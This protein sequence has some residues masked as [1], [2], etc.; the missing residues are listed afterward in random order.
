MEIIDYAEFNP[1]TKNQYE[2]FAI[3]CRVCKD[4]DSEI[5]KELNDFKTQLPKL[6]SSILIDQKFDVAESDKI[7]NQISYQAGKY[8]KEGNKLSIVTSTSDE[9]GNPIRSDKIYQVI[10]E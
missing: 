5:I 10:T 2:S 4:V 3:Y 6:S 8:I 7:K 9:K 1:I